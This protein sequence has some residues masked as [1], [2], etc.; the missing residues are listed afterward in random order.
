MSQPQPEWIINQRVER[1][2]TEQVLKKSNCQWD[3]SPEASGPYNNCL[4]L[5]LV[6]DSPEIV[7]NIYL[8]AQV[9]TSLYEF[10]L[11]CASLRQVCTVLHM[12]KQVYLRVSSLTNIIFV[13]IHLPIFTQCKL[14]HLCQLCQLCQEAQREIGMSHGLFTI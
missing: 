13:Y 6:T 14:C 10:L 1:G 5:L 12:F 11:G 3:V 9:F 7:S 2:E 4:L 8:C